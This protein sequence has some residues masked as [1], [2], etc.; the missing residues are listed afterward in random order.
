[1]IVHKDR[2]PEPYNYNMTSRPP[3]SVL[4]IPQQQHHHH[5]TPSLQHPVP[6]HI[7]QKDHH[8]PS[9]PLPAQ[10]LDPEN[11]APQQKGNSRSVIPSKRAAQNRA[12]QK[13]FRQRREQYIKDLEL[14]AKEMEDWH[15]EMNRLRQENKELREK[16]LVLENQ[17]VALTGGHAKLPELSPAS[18]SPQEQSVE[19]E[20]EVADKTS[21]DETTK[22]TPA[23]SDLHAKERPF[24]PVPLQAPTQTSFESPPHRLDEPLNVDNKRQKLLEDVPSLLNPAEPV[25]PPPPSQHEL[26]ALHPSFWHSNAASGNM[27]NLTAVPTM[28]DFDLDFD[29]DPFFEEEFGPTITNNN[30][31]L[32]NANSGQVLDDLFAMLQTRQRPQIPMI[33][34]EDTTEHAHFSEA[35]G[36]LT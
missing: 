31:F 17:V 32:P 3:G 4:P 24:I 35:I 36:K 19:K 5:N 20:K 26:V 6:Y 1:M 8:I 18:E 11:A 23:T 34:A 16:V 30:D 10:A 7:H 2:V 14:K 25:I 15:D 9:P 28:G 22:Q 29:F 12:A 27:P 33:P 13:A 21:V